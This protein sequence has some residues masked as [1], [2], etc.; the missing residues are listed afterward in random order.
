MLTQLLEASDVAQALKV[1]KSLVYMLIR[2]GELNA[3]K[4]GKTVR[5]RPE[6]LEKFI[7]GNLT[8]TD[9][10]TGENTFLFPKRKQQ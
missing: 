7:S 5:V 3:V 2:T 6:D 10:L 8:G 9:G 1:S 4:F